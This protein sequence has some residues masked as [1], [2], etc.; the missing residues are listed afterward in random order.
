MGLLDLVARVD[1]LISNLQAT[2]QEDAT[3]AANDLAVLIRTRIQQQRLDSKG[4]S[5]GGYSLAVVP[6]WYGIAKAQLQAAASTINKG[7]YFQSY[8]D[9]R[10]ADGLQTESIDFTRTGQMFQQSGVAEVSSST[11]TTTITI[12]GQTAYAK[13]LLG[14]HGDRFGQPLFTPTADEL[15]MVIDSI[16]E[17]V[18]NKINEYLQ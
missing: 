1:L 18:E 16:R 10:E 8:K 14:Y 13:E 6:K 5:F 3:I 17:R 2:R 7:D 11:N 15:Q 12:G 9:F 4:S